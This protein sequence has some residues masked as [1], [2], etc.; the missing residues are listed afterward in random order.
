[1]TLSLTGGHLGGD[2][3]YPLED[4]SF[5]AIYQGKVFWV[6]AKEIPGWVPDFMEDDNEESD[7][8]DATNG[9]ESNGE[10][11]DFKKFSAS[12][13]ENENEVVPDS[14][15]QDE[16]HKING[17]EGYVGQNKAN[18]KDPFTLYDLLNKKKIK[19]TK[20][21]GGR[22]SIWSKETWL[23]EKKA[24]DDVVESMCSG[25]FQKVETPWSG[26]SILQLM[27]DMV[28]NGE[29]IIMGDFNEVRKK[30]KRFGSV[31]NV[32]GADAFNMFISNAGLEEV[33][34]GGYSYTWVHKSATKMSK[35]DRF[36]ISKSLL[37]LCPN[38]SAVSLDRYLSDH[39]CG[40]VLESS[41][42][43]G[44]KCDNQDD[45]KTQ[46]SERKYSHVEQNEYGNN[47]RKLKADLA[48]LDAVID[49]G[50]GDEDVVN[51]RANVDRSLQELE[52][53]QSVEEWPG[54]DAF[55]M[56]ISNAGLEE[57]PL[58]VSLDRYLSDHRPI[59]MRESYY[60]Y[61]PVLFTFFHYW[62]DKEGFDK[63]VEES[64]IEAPVADTN[65]II[66]MMKTLKYQKEKIRAWNKT[67]KE[68]TSNNKRKLKADLAELDVVIDKGKGDEDVVNKRANVDRSLQ[69]LEKLQSVEVA[70][71]AKIKWA[72]KGDE[73]SNEFLSHFKKC[74]DQPQKT[75][76]QLDLNFPNIL[77][78][79]QQAD[80]ECEVTKDEIKRAVW[81]C[82][83]DK[84]RGPDGFTFD[85]Y[86]RY[87]KIIESDVVDAGCRIGEWCS[88]PGN[89]VCFKKRSG[90]WVGG[91][92]VA[93][94]R[95]G[96]VFV[97]LSSSP[98][99]DRL[100]KREANQRIALVS[101]IEL[102]RGKLYRNSTPLMLLEDE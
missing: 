93:W 50:E 81:D 35:L 51:K 97:L 63:L 64:W 74:F 69:E 66:K 29:V 76:L 53:L 21:S 45:E 95:V 92:G 40:R 28:K 67:N 59:L 19:T 83:T 75:H 90:E 18:S 26:G 86:R 71:K 27:D 39:P 4:V 10:D 101:V 14:M 48:E 84:S 11:V 102:D 88:G 46:I 82:G 60:D 41:S 52:K 17:E 6:R 7:I 56:F 12:K 36:L 99:R 62:F 37:S 24:K 9:E 3:G 31:F 61:G 13:G 91:E 96:G 55:N 87:W 58:A 73:N 77:N 85:F 20:F 89:M 47:M 68:G 44:Y 100:K 94:V 30:A 2:R 57:I 70:Q 23:E 15:F 80:L 34:L 42:C 43:C 32:Q 8:D 72:I 38:I 49:K 98:G 25:H 5:K 79:N 16:L 54:A 22:H 33:P 78:S 65:A 1:M